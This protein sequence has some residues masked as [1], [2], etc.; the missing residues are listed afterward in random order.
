MS[1]S[2]FRLNK[3]QERELLEAIAEGDRG[4]VI[5]AGQFLRDLAQRDR[6]A[7]HRSIRRS[8]KQAKAGQ[9]RPTS[10][11]L[12]EIKRRRTR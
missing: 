3:K 4:E 1:G 10:E 8:W 2:D 6:A 9:T 5:D 12:E 7:L 11:L